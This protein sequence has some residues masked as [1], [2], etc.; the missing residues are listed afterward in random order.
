[1]KIRYLI[2]I[3][4]FICVA[5]CSALA[6]TTLVSANNS[7]SISYSYIDD[8]IE[9]QIYRVASNDSDIPE[10]DF[11]SYNVSLDDDN[12]ASTLAAFAL[13]DN[14]T[15]YETE[16]TNDSN[17]AYFD[18]VPSGIYLVTGDT[19]IT[20][21]LKYSVMPVLTYVFDDKVEI[22]AKYQKEKIS[23]S[24]N[25]YKIGVVKV[26]GGSER[27]DNVIAQLLKNGS[28]YDEVELNQSNN[29]RYT[30][31]GLD[32]SADWV[33]VERDVPFKYN[34]SIEKDGDV[35]IIVNTYTSDTPD[36]PGGS[37]P[38]NT[39]EASTETTTKHTPSGGGNVKYITTT[40][41]T[42]ETTTKAAAE[43]VTETTT[44]S[45]YNDFGNDSED[46][47][48]DGESYNDSTPAGTFDDTANKPSEDIDESS[49]N[50]NDTEK[51]DNKEN[52]NKNST[53]NSSNNPSSSDEKLPQTGQLWLPVPVMA[54]LGM[55][56]T[57]FGLFERQK[58]GEYN[59]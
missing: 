55:I 38:P 56:F 45:S 49:P 53:S 26:W 50:D 19:F 5:V 13:R 33:V 16:V 23:T 3:L 24:S 1:M 35:F 32:Q 11:S 30:W 18:N 25:S 39:T 6:V 12:A 34:I 2:R 29:W 40:E 4:S 59:E 44:K 52:N 28:I 10:G 27:E 36:S 57:I 54:F 43:I 51:D 17:N 14:I 8:N 48:N 58:Y 42:T 37:N 15:P 20:G 9:F 46:T 7:G 31:T 22:T 47:T 41:T 21:D